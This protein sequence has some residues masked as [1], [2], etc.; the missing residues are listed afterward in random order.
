[1]P[2][3]PAKGWLVGDRFRTGIDQAGT[4]GPVAIPEWHQSPGLPVQDK[5]AIRVMVSGDKILAGRTIASWWQVGNTGVCGEAPNISLTLMAVTS[6]AKRL[7][8]FR[9]P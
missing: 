5:T 6:W 8:M 4:A 2:E 3:S 7:H 9:S 1:M